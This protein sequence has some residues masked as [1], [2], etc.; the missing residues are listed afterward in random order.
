MENVMNNEPAVPQYPTTASLVYTK[1][2][3]AIILKS[4]RIALRFRRTTPWGE[5]RVEIECFREEKREG[6][7]GEVSVS[8]GFF[9]CRAFIGNGHRDALRTV[10]PRDGFPGWKEYSS[11]E[12]NLYRP[13][14]GYWGLR[15]FNQ[16]VHERAI[17]KML[18]L[19]S[20]LTFHVRL[21]YLTSPVM[22]VAGLHGDVLEL[23]ATKGKNQFVVNLSE[24]VTRH[25]P[26]R[27]GYNF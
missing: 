16:P 15:Y 8:I 26:G 10:E 5:G 18:P 1:E 7:E 25:N 22:A 14:T 23:H 20:Q 13:E 19:G 24:Q 2:V 17:F 12:G 11:E 21:D 27:F 9:E 6:Q 4:H 3:R